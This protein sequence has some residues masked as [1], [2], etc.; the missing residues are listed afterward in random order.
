MDDMS[1]TYLS[2]NT[3][4]MPDEE[5]TDFNKKI[6]IWEHLHL[7]YTPRMF[8]D[9]AADDGADK[10]TSESDG[11]EDDDEAKKASVDWTTFDFAAFDDPFGEGLQK[12]VHTTEASNHIS[13]LN[14]A[15]FE[16]MSTSEEPLP[17]GSHPCDKFYLPI[18]TPGSAA[19]AAIVAEYA[20]RGTPGG[21]TSSGATA[22]A[23]G[24]FLKPLDKM[25]LGGGAGLGGELGNLL[26]DWDRD[27]GQ[28]PSYAHKDDVRP[29]DDEP[30]Y[31]EFLR[32]Q[33]TIVPKRGVID[34]ERVNR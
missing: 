30:K 14:K 19:A 17:F 33:S 6:P 2:T 10:N 25:N 15:A 26:T 3:M 8:A 32:I 13:A 34:D 18:A 5:E 4:A 22:A 12:A 9:R 11:Q 27:R 20:A 23:P 28:E 16:R 24:A 31:R 29:E 1:E 7:P 21:T